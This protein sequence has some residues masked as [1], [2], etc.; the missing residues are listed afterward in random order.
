[1]QVT[2][3]PQQNINTLEKWLKR[4]QRGGARVTTD[5]S[6]RSETRGPAWFMI[7]HARSRDPARDLAKTPSAPLPPRGVELKAPTKGNPVQWVVWPWPVRQDEFGASS[8][9]HCLL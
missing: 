8:R 7:M 5:G 9:H 6:C 4:D 2:G 1:V 3:G